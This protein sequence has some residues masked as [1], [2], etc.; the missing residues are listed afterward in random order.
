[1]FRALVF[2]TLGFAIAVVAGL[3]ISCSFSEKVHEAIIKYTLVAVA[4]KGVL[5]QAV[6]VVQ[7][8]K[9]RKRRRNKHRVS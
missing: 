7:V 9:K 5:L 3:T 4:I 6:S 1:M 8:Q 2:V